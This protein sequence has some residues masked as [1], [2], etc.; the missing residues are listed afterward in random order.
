MV[1][2][3]AQLTIYRRSLSQTCSWQN[4]TN[5]FQK[6]QFSPTPPMHQNWSVMILN[7]NSM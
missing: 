6:I 7:I 1:V 4:V 2:L 3:R 5:C